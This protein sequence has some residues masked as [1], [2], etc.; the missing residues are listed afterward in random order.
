VFELATGFS[1]GALTAPFAYLGS[2]HDPQL[3]AVY[4]E[5]TPER[6]LYATR[7]NSN[8]RG[9]RMADG[10]GGRRAG[11]GRPVGS[12]WKPAVGALRTETIEK[13]KAIVGSERDPLSVE[14]DWVLDDKFDIQTRLSA[15]HVCLPFL[16]PRL[17]S[18]SVDSRNVTVH[19][20]SR[21]VLERLTSRI[22]RLAPMIDRELPAASPAETAEIGQF[23]PRNSG[24]SEA[25]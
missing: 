12:G 22:G 5:L 19:V 25:A 24:P 13:M 9:A 3:R 6:V 17:N 16:Y 7:W 8:R 18:T 11:A 15:A 10:H 21:A 14:V 1:T 2:S 20:D 23:P 4:T